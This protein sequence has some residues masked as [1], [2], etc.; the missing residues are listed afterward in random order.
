MQNEIFTS[1]A[2]STR[3]NNENF[4]KY[5]KLYLQKLIKDVYKSTCNYMNKGLKQFDLNLKLKSNHKLWKKLLTI[6]VEYIPRL[7]HSW[8]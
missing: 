3:I 2:Y 5:T 7:R 6:R 1:L 4:D 8:F